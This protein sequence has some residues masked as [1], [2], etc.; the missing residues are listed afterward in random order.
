MD[1]KIDGEW[2][3]RMVELQ[4]DIPDP[5][6]YLTLRDVQIMEARRAEREA[7]EQNGHQNGHSNGNGNGN[8]VLGIPLGEAVAKSE[9]PVS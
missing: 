2:L 9:E 1:L 8:G 5:A 7:A 3:K 6:P 4:G